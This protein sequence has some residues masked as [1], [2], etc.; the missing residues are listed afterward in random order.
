MDLQNIWQSNVRVIRFGNAKLIFC[1]CLKIVI[2]TIMN[3][4]FI[5][6]INYFNVLLSIVQV[7][8]VTTVSF[9]LKINSK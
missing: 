5:W 6:I 3:V 4:C 8:I 2:S 7:I 1:S 9:I